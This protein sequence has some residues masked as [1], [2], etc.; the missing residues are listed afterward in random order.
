[1][2]K[3]VNMIGFVAG[4]LT[5]IS[6]AGER[7]MDGRVRW[8]CHC[9]CGNEKIICGKELRNG[10]TKS[11]GCIG[12][13]IKRNISKE[14]DLQ[15]KK[16]ADKN[17]K[18]I[19]WHGGTGTS[20][21]TIWKGIKRRCNNPKEKHYVEYGA[22][23][24]KVCDRWLNSFPDFLSDMGVRPTKL[25]SIDRIDNDG[26]YEPSNCRWA[27][28]MEQGRNKRNNRWLEANGIKKHLQGWADF[29]NIP[30]STL[31]SALKVNNFE[32]IYLKYANKNKGS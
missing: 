3:K 12:S 15:Y 2:P 23:G 17:L 9:I 1:M 27:T 16:I 28:K 19:V 21:Y 24:I 11:C 20:E 32:T 5:V 31:H 22:R 14:Q 8:L 6:E 7:S 25:H 26:N 13:P 30:V 29:F 4:R 18:S 10:D